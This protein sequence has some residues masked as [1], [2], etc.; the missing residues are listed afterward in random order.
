[1]NIEGWATTIEGSRSIPELLRSRVGLTPERLAYKVSVGHGWKSVLWRDLL[2][3][4]DELAAGLVALGIEPGEKIAVIGETRPEWGLCDLAALSVGALTVGIYQTGTPEQWAHVIGDSGAVLVFVDGD[5]RLEG[6]RLVRGRLGGLRH[7]VCWVSPSEGLDRDEGERSLFAV[8]KMGREADESVKAEVLRRSRAIDPASG[9]NLVYTSG[10]TGPPK[11]AVI[12]HRN[13]MAMLNQPRRPPLLPDDITLSFLP[14][15]HVAEKVVS[16]YGRMHAGVATAYAR[17][18]DFQLIM[19]DMAVI[20]P[21]VF[22]S[23]PRIFEKIHARAQARA[24]ARGKVGAAMWRWAADV[25]RRS[26]RVERGLEAPSRRLALQ[27]SLADK[28]IYSKL[29]AVFGGRVR[30]FMSGAAPISVELLEFFHGAGMLILEAY[31]MTESTAISTSNHPDEFKFGTVGKPIEGVELRLAEDGEIL[32]RG[33]TV[34]GGYHGQP[35]ATAEAIDAEGWLHTGDIGEVDAE[36]FVKIVDRKKNLIITAGGKN[37]APQNIENLVK[38]DPYIANCVV[39]GDRRPFLVALVTLD[40]D[41]VVA[42]CGLLEVPFSGVEAL[43]GEAKVVAHVQ[44]AV[45][46]ANAQLGQVERIKKCR[47]LPQDLSIEAGE[48]TPTL[49]TRRQDITRIHAAL[50]DEMY[51]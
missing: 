42:L 1:M 5:E 35:E 29:R 9:A 22:G 19:E 44:A 41:E 17:S 2:A 7:V 50:I 43:A 10:T 4:V 36:G 40:E 23:V 20:R 3:R 12:T 24:Q 6:V 37:I 34:F 27:R 38:E 14:M 13:V 11:G 45:D 46:R 51:I 15:C 48:L 25:A 47:I 28:L 49:K 21:T 18:L 16:F 31:G 32:V 26:S 30:F 33:Q 8:M 39:I